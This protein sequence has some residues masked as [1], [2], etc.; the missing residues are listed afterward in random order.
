MAPR[1][2]PLL[3][4]PILAVVPGHRKEGR[5]A[6]VTPLLGKPVLAVVP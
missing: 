1:V 6:R 2:T 5:A 4:K 3:G